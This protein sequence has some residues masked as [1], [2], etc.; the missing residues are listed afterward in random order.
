MVKS[1]MKRNLLGCDPEIIGVR[2]G[3]VEVAELFGLGTRTKI[4]ADEAGIQF[5]LRPDPAKLPEQIVDNL[6]VLIKRLHENFP[7]LSFYGGGFP[8]QISCG[9]HLHFSYRFGKYYDRK[10]LENTLYL[11]LGFPLMMVDGNG[12]KKRRFESYGVW[13][14][15]RSQRHG[16][17][18]RAP[19]SFITNKKYTLSVF[20]LMYVILNE[21]KRRANKK[22]KSRFPLPSYLDKYG[23]PLDEFHIQ[24]EIGELFNESFRGKQSKNITKFVWDEIEKFDM[25]PSYKREISVLRDASINGRTL[26]TSN[27]PLSKGWGINKSKHYMI[28]SSSDDY[29]GNMADAYYNLLFDKKIFLF[30]LSDERKI[31]AILNCNKCYKLIKK[32]R[33]LLNIS[34]DFKNDLDDLYAG[35]RVNKKELLIGLSY[36]IRLRNRDSKRIMNIITKQHMKK[37][38]SLV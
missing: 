4:G 31:D 17:E 28:T 2:N 23:N 8:R 10:S 34:N 21:I 15:M 7:D 18:L 36:D 1:V 9:G 33:P 13:G 30:G 25:Y 19:S 14:D 32:E 37:K 22:K 3:D 5:E 16:W 29:V 38:R 20:S 6:H 24:Y 26:F 27:L 12:G 11:Y 35:R